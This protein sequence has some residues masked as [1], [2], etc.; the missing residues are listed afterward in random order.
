M[1]SKCN[2]KTIMKDYYFQFAEGNLKQVN[3]HIDTFRYLM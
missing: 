2:P 1:I 3:K